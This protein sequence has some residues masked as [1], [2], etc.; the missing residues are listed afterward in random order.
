MLQ[1]HMSLGIHPCKITPI[2]NFYMKHTVDFMIS[3]FSFL[4]VVV[5]YSQARILA[6]DSQ[7]KCFRS[8]DLDQ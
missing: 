2:S 7:K 8:C 3:I 5:L 6:I 1:R 4:R